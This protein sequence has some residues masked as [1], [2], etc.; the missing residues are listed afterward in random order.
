MKEY[1]GLKVP[2]VKKESFYLDRLSSR[3]CS[4]ESVT[5]GGLVC[6]DCLFGNQNKDTLRQYLAEKEKKV[7]VHC[8]TKELW[9]RV[10][11][12]AFGEGYYWYGD[13]EGRIAS[14]KYSDHIV[15]DPDDR[16]ITHTI[17]PDDYTIISAEGYLG[18][19]KG[20]VFTGIDYSKTPGESYFVKGTVKPDGTMI[21]TETGQFNT[22]QEDTM[23][24][25]MNDSI[26][27][28]FKDKTLEEA[29]VIQSYFGD[30]IP[31]DDFGVIC[32]ENVK[33]KVFSEAMS[34][35]KAEKEA[36]KK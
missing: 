1:K 19:E 5:C 4:T 30:S 20:R 35:R 17:R 10:Q 9:D 2:K 13:N 8:P 3:V 33:D 16:D 25:E 21:I 23:S 12:K 34:R 24:E 22:K 15:V 14:T 28:V 31:E 29:E 26:R 27:Q 7:A 32:L 18:E 36:A 11:E 6:N